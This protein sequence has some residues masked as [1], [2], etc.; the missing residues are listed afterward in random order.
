MI[1]FALHIKWLV[2]IRNATLGW[3]GLVKFV[4]QLNE[5]FGNISD[6]FLC[7]RLVYIL[8]IIKVRKLDIN[9]GNI[10]IRQ[11]SK[12][13]DEILVICVGCMLDKV[14]SLEK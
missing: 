10:K 1:A 3:N 6:W 14:I 4:K 5:D 9:Y 13:S 7:N 11:H 8:A 2:A 12:I